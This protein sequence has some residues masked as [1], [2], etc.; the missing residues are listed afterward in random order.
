MK[1][2]IGIDSDGDFK[3]E[4]HLFSKLAIRDPK[5]ELMHVEPALLVGDMAGAASIYTDY[6][7]IQKAL[8]LAG[9]EVLT[10]AQ[11]ELIYCGYSA[12]TVYEQGNVC[13]ALSERADK[14]HADLIVIGSRHKSAYGAFLLGSVGRGLTIGG[15]HSLLIA[16]REIAPTGKMTAVFATDGSE[17]AD[18]CLRMFVRMRPQGIGRLAVVTAVDQLENGRPPNEIKAHVD[19]LVGHLR[20]E[21]FEADGHV[22]EG[23]VPEVIDT[24]MASTHADLLIMGAQGHSFAERLMVGSIS[25]KE[26]VT[27][28]HSVLL[29][30]TG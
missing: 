30:R 9:E 29:L 22:V 23:S 17:Y 11:A 24:M 18:A 1:I 12:E 10:D 27:R 7:S 28:P 4:L 13:E 21:C 14:T 16:K 8:Q 3:P 6:A 25:L 15:H 2:L 5:I 19:R 26:V 20:D